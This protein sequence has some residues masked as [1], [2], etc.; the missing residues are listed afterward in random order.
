[1]YQRSSLC[2]PAWQ[3]TTLPG[4]THSHRWAVF[5]WKAK[6]HITHSNEMG[7]SVLHM[8][9]TLVK[10]ISYISENPRKKKVSPIRGK[11]YLLSVPVE[12]RYSNVDRSILSHNI[13]S[14]TDPNLGSSILW[15][16]R[17]KRTRKIQIQTRP[18]DLQVFV[19]RCLLRCHH[20]GSDYDYWN[21]HQSNLPGA[22]QEVGISVPVMPPR[23]YCWILKIQ[24]FLKA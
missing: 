16:Q 12:E 6:V 22:L 14:S 10:N 3:C 19:S 24:I 18:H 13:S 17:S 11:W 21:F 4:P 15:D 7:C 8:F 20:R 2:S 9:G 1:M 23:F 5:H